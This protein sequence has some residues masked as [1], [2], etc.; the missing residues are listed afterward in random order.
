[1]VRLDVNERGKR[2]EMCVG[3]LWLDAE[4]DLLLSYIHRMLYGIFIGLER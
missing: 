4:R 3:R 2:T 1:M